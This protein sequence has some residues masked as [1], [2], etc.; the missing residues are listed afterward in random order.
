[1]WIKGLNIIIQVFRLVLGFSYKK[2]VAFVVG[3]QL[4]KSSEQG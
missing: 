4:A 2:H 1:M 3:D